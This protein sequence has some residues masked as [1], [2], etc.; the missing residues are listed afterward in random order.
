MTTFKRLYAIY[1]SVAGFYS[2]VFQAENDP[3]AV[4]MFDQSIDHAHKGDFSLW[5]LAEYDQDT[6][7]IHEKTPT[8]T[9]HGN[10]LPKKGAD[11]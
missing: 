4:R 5:F 8:Q 7:D 2:P 1:D 3:H 6:G 10:S 11:Q 9:L